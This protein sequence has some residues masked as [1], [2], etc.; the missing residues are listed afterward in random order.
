M[1]PIPDGLEYRQEYWDGALSLIRRRERR[2]LLWRSTFGALLAVLLVGGGIGYY[3]MWPANGTHL[4]QVA[5]EISSSP[6]ALANHA[7]VDGQNAL[8]ISHQSEQ[9]PADY[10][11]HAS[12][13]P[14]YN[15]IVLDQGALF[16]VHSG[17]T[18]APGT[19]GEPVAQGN[20]NTPFTPDAPNGLAAG[21][22]GSVSESSVTSGSVVSAGA[23]PLGSE[24]AMSATA[25]PADSILQFEVFSVA[26]ASNTRTHQVHSPELE[27]KTPDA[28]LRSQNNLPFVGAFS[29]VLQA[30]MNN[31]DLR[32]LSLGYNNI[33][34]P[35]RVYPTKPYYLH[36]DL[37]TSI[38]NG[39]GSSNRSALNPSLGLVVERNLN[40]TWSVF[41]GVK[42]FSITNI[43]GALNT[44]DSLYRDDTIV[45]D[46]LIHMNTLH[47]VSVPV[48]LA[49][50]FGNGHQLTWDAGV[51]FISQVNQTQQ[52]ISED[53]H[54]LNDAELPGLKPVKGYLDGHRNFAFYMGIG[55][56]YQLNSRLAL[57][58]RFQYG[59]T[60]ITN[61]HYQWVKKRDDRN[62]KTELFVRMNLW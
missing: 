16:G 60:D 36:L 29:P 51:S 32:P 59:L 35:S 48:G 47:L 22:E 53:W 49:M 21:G 8:Y 42:F 34:E 24:P 40:P 9:S 58:G 7:D 45:T 46:T 4:T 17:A 44:T 33:E 19:T 50:R 5:G 28:T 14:G 39:Y 11:T 23:V 57:G 41:G 62:S 43:T 18:N 6:F 30:S 37:G 31:G 1:E 38:F 25:T 15:G 54:V 20:R 27:G 13:K 52:V 3:Y 12:S 26:M 56:N 61:N 10:N 2:V 55:Y